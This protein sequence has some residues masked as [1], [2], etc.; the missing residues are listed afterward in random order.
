M[1]LKVEKRETLV[2]PTTVTDYPSSGEKE[3][4]EEEDP[5]LKHLE[6][7]GGGGGVVSIPKI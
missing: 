1:R 2:T 4:E 6:N 5:H 7:G 3:M